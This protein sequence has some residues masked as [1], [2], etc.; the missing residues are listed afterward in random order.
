MRP[1]ASC[2]VSAVAYS[3]PFAPVCGVSKLLGLLVPMLFLGHPLFSLLAVLL[4]PSLALDNVAAWDT[5][6]GPLL[7]L[8]SQAAFW[9]TM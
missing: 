1:L 3:G 7:L 8:L 2:P 4:T 9:D 5:L 6:Y